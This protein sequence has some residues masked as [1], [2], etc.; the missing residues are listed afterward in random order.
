[1]Q[2]EYTI[3]WRSL[4]NQKNLDYSWADIKCPSWRLSYSWSGLIEFADGKFTVPFFKKIIMIMWLI[5]IISIILTLIS[6]KAFV[7]CFRKIPD[8]CDSGDHW[9]SGSYCFYHC[10]C[11][12]CGTKQQKVS[13][14]P[15]PLDRSGERGKARKH[16]S[17]VIH[18][19]MCFFW[20]LLYMWPIQSWNNLITW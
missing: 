10:S 20:I 18:S 17:L 8:G 2:N 19:Q 7:S 6:I 12:I 3:T 14:L 13:N 11:K 15:Y 5:A 4:G 1:M 9:R 16:Q